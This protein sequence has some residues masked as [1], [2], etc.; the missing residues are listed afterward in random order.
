MKVHHIT[1]GSKGN[2]IVVDDGYSSLVLDAG[3]PYSKLS[4]EIT[5][6]EVS[7]VLITHAHTDHSAA[8]GELIRRGIPVTM[9]KGTCRELFY[10]NI[11][12]SGFKSVG[13]RPEQVG[14][15]VLDYEVGKDGKKEYYQRRFG[16]WIVKPFPVEHDAEEPLGFFCKSMNTDKKVVYVADSGL[17]EFDFPGTTHF[18]L[19]CNYIEEKLAAGDY[20]EVVKRRIRRNHFSLKSLKTFLRT[21]DLSKTEEIWLV[22]LSGANSDEQRFKDEIQRLTGVPVYSV[23]D[24]KNVQQGASKGALS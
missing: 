18:I 23:S 20:P 1:S 3:L 24:A 2:C 10:K 5:F 19:E 14:V 9:S 17:I 15:I 21:S 8:A 12:P 4:R 7:G 22:H 13:F 11:R 6:S 16:E